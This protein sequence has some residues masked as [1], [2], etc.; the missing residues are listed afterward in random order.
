M[1]KNQAKKNVVPMTEGIEIKKEDPVDSFLPKK[2][3]FRIDEVADYFSV[4]QHTIRTWIQHSIIESEKIA[5]GS[6][7]ISRGAILRCRFNK[8]V[9]TIF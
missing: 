6:V 4:D 9:G 3:L 2:D 5:S 1:A 7:R 8:V